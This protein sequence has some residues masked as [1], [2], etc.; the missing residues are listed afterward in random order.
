MELLYRSTR[1][2]K[3]P[4]TASKAI[5]QGLAEDGGLFVQFPK[6]KK[7]VAIFLAFQSQAFHT[8]DQTGN[9]IEDAISPDMQGAI[10]IICALL[11]RSQQAKQIISILNRS[12]KKIVLDGWAFADRQKRKQYL[13]GQSIEPGSF[14]SIPVESNIVL[15]KEG[16]IITLLDNKGIKIDGVS[17]TQKDCLKE[18]WTTKF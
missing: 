18:G 4:V 9:R 15:P 10:K 8:D 16:G 1:G 13:H 2:A 7:W 6:Q 5:L 14:L 11:N 12:E 3:E 17:Y